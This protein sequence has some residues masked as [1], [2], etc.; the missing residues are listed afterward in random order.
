MAPRPSALGIAP[1]GAPS[2]RR[3]PPGPPAASVLVEVRAA[4]SGVVKALRNVPRD[5]IIDR[6]EMLHFLNRQA[7]ALEQVRDRALPLSPPTPSRSPTPTTGA[8]GGRPSSPP[9]SPRDRAEAIFRRPAEPDRPQMI[10]PRTPA[11]TVLCRKGRQVR[12][13]V[14]RAREAGQLEMPI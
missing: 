8:S 14:R 9:V 11:R 7:R 13:E 1:V 12:V 6:A 10:R 2:P 3:T 5:C 4:L